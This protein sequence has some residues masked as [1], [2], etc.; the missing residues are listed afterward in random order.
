VSL[1]KIVSLLERMGYSDARISACITC[2]VDN[3]PGERAAA[4]PVSEKPV[5]KTTAWRMKK[6]AEARNGTE[7]SH[8]YAVR[9]EGTSNVKIGVSKNVKAR[10]A[11]LQTASPHP[12]VLIGCFPGEESD[13]RR[14]HRLLNHRHL[15]GEWFDF[16][17]HEGVLDIL[18]DHLEGC[19][20]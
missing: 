15:R 3:A 12:L 8:V 1:S 20:S 16:Q 18:F 17:E 7:H 14:L 5:P 9:A 2:I 4:A 13:E 6:A 19:Q 10:V 11:A